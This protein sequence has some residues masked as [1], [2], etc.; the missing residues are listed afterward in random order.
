MNDDSTFPPTTALN[1]YSSS[2]DL[3][4]HAGRVIPG[5]STARHRVAG[6]RE[7][8]VLDLYLLCNLS[9]NYYASTIVETFSAI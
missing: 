7:T 2:L 9:R 3:T 1:Y 6:S 5:R 4:K 8:G